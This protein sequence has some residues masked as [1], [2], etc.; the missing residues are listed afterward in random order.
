MLLSIGLLNVLDD[1]FAIFDRTAAVQAMTPFVMTSTSSGPS[2][3]SLYLGV[4]GMRSN[5]T[6]VCTSDTRPLDTFSNRKPL[7]VYTRLPSAETAS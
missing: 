4:N 5:S 2:S 6:T 3:F 7:Y 1:A